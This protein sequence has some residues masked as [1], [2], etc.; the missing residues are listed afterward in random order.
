MCEKNIFLGVIHAP[1]SR[2][3]CPSAPQILGFPSIYAFIGQSRWAIMVPFDMLAMDCGIVT[4]SVRRTIFE[5]FDFKNAMTLKTELGVRLG[6]WKCHHST[7]H[8]TS[9]LRSIITMALSRVVSEIPVFNVEK[10]H[11]LEIPVK[12][13]WQWYHSIDWIWFPLV[14]YNNFVT[15][16]NS[17]WDI[18]LVI[19]QWPWNPDYGLLKVIGTDTD[20][21]AAY[22]F[23]LTFHSNHGPSSYRFRDKR[24]FKSKIAK[25]PWACAS[26]P[27]CLLLTH[28][29]CHR[30]RGVI[31]RTR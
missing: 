9:Y 10:Y 11:Y 24:R 28:V 30:V 22:D 16:T 29:L 27:T 31:A 7:E 3:W 12:G 26:L 15:R 18:R 17:S 8:M 19:I 25:F 2:G 20:R 23:I 13:R 4:L 1:I 14:F 21:P 6:H 5:L